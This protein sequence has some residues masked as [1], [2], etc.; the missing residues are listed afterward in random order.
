MFSDFIEQKGVKTLAIVFGAPV[1]TIYSW[2][3][4]NA[5]PRERWDKLLELY[6]R[7][8]WQKLREMES[9]SRAEKTE[10]A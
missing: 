2:K 10:A 8:S 6:P 1:Q 3:R 4:R 7:L 9:A 5:I